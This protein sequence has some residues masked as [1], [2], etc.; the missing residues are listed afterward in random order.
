MLDSPTKLGT[1]ATQLSDYLFSHMSS[2]TDEYYEQL[3]ASRYEGLTR[4]NSGA[5]SGPTPKYGLPLAWAFGMASNENPGLN[6]FA[7]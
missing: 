3:G 6:T 4:T 2:L 5:L 7:P 1:Y